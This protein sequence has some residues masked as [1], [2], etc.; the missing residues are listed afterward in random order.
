M[1]FPWLATLTGLR[2]KNFGDDIFLQ[3]LS[4]QRTRYWKRMMNLF[5]QPTSGR[6]H[7]VLSPCQKFCHMFWSF[8]LQLSIPIWY[9][10]SYIYISQFWPPISLPCSLSW[11]GFLNWVNSMDHHGSCLTAQVHAVLFGPNLASHLPRRDGW[12]WMDGWMWFSCAQTHECGSV[13]LSLGCA[14][15]SCW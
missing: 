15:R 13:P 14:M 5:H 8:L 12:G 9:N 11:P 3:L 10:I 4:M 7:M 1:V 6:W 2:F